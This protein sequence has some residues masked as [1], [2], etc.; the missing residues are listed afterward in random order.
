M[1]DPARFAYAISRVYIHR[2]VKVYTRNGKCSYGV[3]VRADHEYVRL[4]VDHDSL[5][6]IELKVRT[7][8]ILGLSCPDLATQP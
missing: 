8:E 6:P 2:A 4:I 5:D 1:K 3:L 7:N